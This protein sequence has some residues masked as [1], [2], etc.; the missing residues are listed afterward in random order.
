M[1]VEILTPEH[2]GLCFPN[3]HMVGCYCC[4]FIFH[5]PSNDWAKHEKSQLPPLEKYRVY[6]CA[7]KS[8]KDLSTWIFFLLSQVQNI[9]I[10]NQEFGLSEIEP[11]NPFYYANFDGILGMAY[12]NLAVGDSPTVMQSMVQQGQLT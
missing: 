4:P 9:V 8:G 6:P 2:S 10:N 11:S 5:T 1:E 12:P 7:L 3:T